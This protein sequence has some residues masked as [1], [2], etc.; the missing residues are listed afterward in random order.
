M[1]ARC[2]GAS[3]GTL[4]ETLGGAR[5][6]ESVIRT[7][8]CRSRTIFDLGRPVRFGNPRVIHPRDQRVASMRS[9]TSVLVTFCSTSMPSASNR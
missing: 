5:V 9:A 3:E 7:H 4:C 8:P 1:P 2:G 6:C